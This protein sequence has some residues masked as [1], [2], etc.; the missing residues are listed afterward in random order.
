MKNEEIKL[1]CDKIYSNIEEGE[2]RL[3]ELR[4]MCK[5]EKTYEG[6]YSWRVGSYQEAEICEYCGKLIKYFTTEERLTK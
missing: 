3:K 4:S 6:T 2:K 1:E 5:H